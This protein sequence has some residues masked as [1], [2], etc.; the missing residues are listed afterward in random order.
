LE[1]I[2][3]WACE[4]LSYSNLVGRK[5]IDRKPLRFTE[6]GVASSFDLQTPKDQRWLE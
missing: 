1:L 6:D 4:A 3:G 2:L 5:N